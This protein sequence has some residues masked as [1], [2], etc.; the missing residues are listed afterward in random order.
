M[1][2]HIRTRAPDPHAA[3]PVAIATRRDL[4][5][6][7]GAFLLLTAVEAGDAKAQELDGELM[8]CCSELLA[9]DAESDRLDAVAAATD[10]G[11]PRHPAW[12]ACDDH[13]LATNERWHELTDKIAAT[14]ARTPE[15]L[16]AK[17]QAARTAIHGEAKI[18]PDPMDRLAWSVFDDVLGRACA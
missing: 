9:I 3:P 16:R 2:R 15:G 17:V 6:T 4:F 1:S 14:P 5:G 12:F 8:A 18:N 11:D 7:M 13:S 10:G